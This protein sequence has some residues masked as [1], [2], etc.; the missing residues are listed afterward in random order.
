[1]ETIAMEDNFDPDQQSDQTEEPIPESTPPEQPEVSKDAKNM[2]MLCHLLG[3]LTNF[4]GPLIL[5][6]IKKDDDPFIDDQGKEAL[7]WQIT[8]MIAY[9]VGGITSAICIGFVII[10]A[11]G[12]CQVVF[13]II[14]C[15]KASEGIAYR[16]PFC[17]RLVK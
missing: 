11:A 16:Y 1:M 10:A 13:G 15:I 7:N 12:I 4:I 17:L 14:G 2:G 8:L 9:V 6:I 5:W 3:L